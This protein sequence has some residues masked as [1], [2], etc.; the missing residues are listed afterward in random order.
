MAAKRADQSSDLLELSR[1]VVDAAIGVTNI[2]EQ[3]HFAIL[4]TTQSFAPPL[5]GRAVA[6]VTSFVYRCAKGAMRL[7]GA[8]L[9]AVLAN[10]GPQLNE[11]PASLSRLRPPAAR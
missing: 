7:T 3:T 10:S 4:R 9:D 2:A 8:A 1:L 6:D 5:A 11:M